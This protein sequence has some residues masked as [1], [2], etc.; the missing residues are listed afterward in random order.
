MDEQDTKQNTELKKSVVQS[1]LLCLSRL[2]MFILTSKFIKN[3]KKIKQAKKLK[4][5]ILLN[6]TRTEK[7][8]KKTARGR[9]ETYILFYLA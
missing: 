4:A 9:F 7:K 1:V 2:F 8:K 5:W 3:W 6:Q